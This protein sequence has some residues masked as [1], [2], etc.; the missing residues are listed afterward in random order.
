[1][2]LIDL[3]G[4]LQKIVDDVDEASDISKAVVEN[5]CDEATQVIDAAKDIIDSVDN[6]K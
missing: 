2:S 5:V 3:A 1:M 4:K 6:I